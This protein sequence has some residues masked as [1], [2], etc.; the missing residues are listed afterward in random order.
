MFLAAGEAERLKAEFALAATQK[1]DYDA[2]AL[3][4][5]DFVHGLDFLQAQIQKYPFL[6]CA[7]VVRADTGKPLATPVVYRTYRLQAAPNR[8]ARSVTVAIFGVI[9][10]SLAGQIDGYIKQPLKPIRVLDPIAESRKIVEAARQK[11]QLVVALAHMED[12][13]GKELARR[14]PGID[15]IVLGHAGFRRK[16]TEPLRIDSTLLVGESDQGKYMGQLSLTLNSNGKIEASAG[17]SLPIDEAIPENSEIAKMYEEVKAE[18]AKQAVQ[19]MSTAPGKPT[20][21]GAVSCKACHQRQY[22]QWLGTRHAAAFASLGLRDKTNQSKPECV[23]CHSAGFGEPG[24]F[25][26]MQITPSL[27]SVQCENCHGQGARHV[28]AAADAKKGSVVRLPGAA[29]CQKCHD[30]ENDPE[31]DYYQALAAVKH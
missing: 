9:S 30:K 11:A 1:M 25:V 16:I 15:V 31:F 28:V 2:V 7:N 19:A 13:Q 18:L 26:S 20:F 27:A 8:P 10:D 21:I 22:D 14:V 23:R 6:T 24:G 12:E 4:E 3:G 5:L 29:T 17:T